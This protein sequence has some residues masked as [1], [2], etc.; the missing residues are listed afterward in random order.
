MVFLDCFDLV[1]KS[2][3]KQRIL[4]GN[5]FNMDKK[6]FLIVVGGN[7]YKAIVRQS[8]CNYFSVGSGNRVWAT[9]I[10]SVS[11]RGVVIGPMIIFEG[12]K[13]CRTGPLN[14]LESSMVLVIMDGVIMN[15]GFLASEIA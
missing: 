1:E 10:E 8:A 3:C 9:V 2:I 5:M 14:T 6:R 15:M 12:K 11:T 13:Y 4:I 7:I